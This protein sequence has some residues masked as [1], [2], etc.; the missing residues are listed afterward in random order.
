MA[1]DSPEPLDSRASGFPGR[2][3]ER[4]SQGPWKQRCE[5]DRE[6]KWPGFSPGKGW[7]TT[8][9][10]GQGKYLRLCR[11]SGLRLNYPVVSLLQG[12]A[13]GAAEWLAYSIRQQ[14]R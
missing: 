6:S 8:S 14:A 12:N 7:P 4:A 13:L 3:A 9:V 1:Q 11:L 10:K 2:L 5:G